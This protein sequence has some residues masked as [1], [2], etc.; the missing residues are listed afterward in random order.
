M[1]GS[2]F[3]LVVRF[4]ADLTLLIACS[5]YKKLCIIYSAAQNN[6]ETL[7]YMNRNCLKAIFECTTM[8]FYNTER[9]KD[10]EFVT[11]YKWKLLKA[12][13][14]IFY[15]FSKRYTHET[16]LIYITVYRYKY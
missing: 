1:I 11:M 5:V 4:K 12:N 2:S 9:A 14:K 10:C 7:H 15:A 13:F 3:H 6:T 8:R 16:I